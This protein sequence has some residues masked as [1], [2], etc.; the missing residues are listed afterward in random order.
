M[1]AIRRL[2]VLFVSVAATTAVVAEAIERLDDWK[3]RKGFRG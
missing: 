2:A 1:T 3:Y